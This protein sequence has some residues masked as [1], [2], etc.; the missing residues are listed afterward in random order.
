MAYC[1]AA[2]SP[3]EVS[4]SIPARQRILL[5]VAVPYSLI[6]LVIW[7][8][9]PWQRFLWWVAALAVAAIAALSYQGLRSLGLRST[10]LRA[11]GLLAPD[12][13]EGFW[14][15]GTAILLVAAAVV[16]AARMHT[17]HLPRGGAVGL[18]K[19]YWLYALWSCVQQLLLQ[20]FFL[21]RFLVLF[22]KPAHAALIAAALFSLAHLPNPILTV[23]TCVWGFVACLLFLRYRTLM[24]LCI[25][26]A[27][28]GI[29]LAITLPG[30]V[31]HNMRVGLGY[32]TYHNA[33]HRHIAT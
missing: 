5:E 24:P 15:V 3:L 2:I 9:R 19:A 32:L 28:L 17:I 26:H 18:I 21:Q 23:V 13:I 8:P 16:L 27:I 31:I 4:G 12:F 11:R 10:S 30:P 14:I 6:L 1:A 33:A 25:S 29:T 22:N 7:T 20:G